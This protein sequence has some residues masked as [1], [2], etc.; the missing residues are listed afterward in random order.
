MLANPNPNPNPNPNCIPAGKWEC[1]GP[2]NL[3]SD[4][5]LHL[6][7]GAT[8]QFSTKPEDYPLVLTKFEG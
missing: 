6:A 5:Q 7:A 3:K 1:N 4:V 2:V 8:L